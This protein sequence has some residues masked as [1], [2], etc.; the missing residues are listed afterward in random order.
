MNIINTG[1]GFSLF[2]SYISKNAV[3]SFYLST[4]TYFRKV[5]CCGCLLIFSAMSIASE[6]KKYQFD[7]PQQSLAK[8]LNE[9]SDHT[10]TLV[11]FPYDLVEKRKETL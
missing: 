11:L 6:Q 8:S 1:S 9:L 10:K 5:F 3:R 2:V 7:I 4:L